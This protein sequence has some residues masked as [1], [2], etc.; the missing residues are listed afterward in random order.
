MPESRLLVLS[1]ARLE[2][3][4]VSLANAV[5]AMGIDAATAVVGAAGELAAA[6][7]AQPCASAAAISA[8]LLRDRGAIDLATLERAL[9][10]RV[11]HCLVFD[12]W[13]ADASSR[14][15]AA[16][17]SGPFAVMHVS[18][19]RYAMS[20][21]ARDVLGPLAGLKGE[22][23]ES[24]D[25]PVYRVSA[26]QGPAADATII[27]VDD[28]PVFAR[29]ASAG[30]DIFFWITSR[31][32]DVN[33]EVDGDGDLDAFHLGM[34]APLAFAR[35]AFGEQCWHA[36]QP[37]ARLTIDDPLIRPRYGFLR[38]GELLASMQRVHYGVTVGFIPWNHRRSSRA[39][40]QRL[41]AAGAAFGI[42]AHGCDHTNQEFARVDTALAQTLGTIAASR[43]SAHQRDSGLDWDRVM[44]FPQ[45]LFST[46]AMAGL[47]DAGFLAAVNST[48]FPHD[49]PTV[50]LSL[51]EL[52]DPAVTRFGG[53]PVFRR[54][55][56]QERLGFAFDLFVG[57]PVLICEHHQFFRE[58]FA[59]LEALV[60]FVRGMEPS[61]QWPSLHDIVVR[62]CRQRR[63]VEGWE[64]AFYGRELVWRN[65]AAV[66][67]L[68]R[69]CTSDTARQVAAVQIDDRDVRHDRA[70]TVLA[71]ETRVPAHAQVHVRL[72]S[73]PVTAPRTA[74]FGVSHPAKV[75]LR[76]MLSELRDNW[77][78][79][80]PAMLWLAS[81]LARAVKATGDS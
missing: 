54:R 42:C 36:A 77:L 78:S 65:P 3:S 40:A 18:P 64:V 9:P 15:R 31:V 13:P 6:L 62:A 80:Q 69:F 17:T 75:A 66:P 8:D 81:R 21:A 39:L 50:R 71:F 52:M 43:M 4:A 12:V 1:S 47:A 72:V 44:I 35:A 51:R 53:A 23:C 26:D 32:F 48:C 29:V 63:T 38:Y 34:I 30:R 2:S 70:D 22:H 10:P 14:D 49:D 11:R 46:A 20:A 59:P 56:P 7:Q 27:E 57:R 68:V 25:V 76:R 61:L 41:A 37:M 67:Q 45:G 58:G 33:G 24:D 55:Y 74:G 16:S 73:R 5:R 19:T 60:D 79:Q 28:H